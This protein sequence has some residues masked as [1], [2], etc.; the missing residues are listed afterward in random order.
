MRLNDGWM[1]FGRIFYTLDIMVW[2]VR[3]LDILS[4]NKLMGPYVNMIGKMVGT[5]QKSKWR[6]AL[7]FVEIYY[8]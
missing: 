6:R 4:V 1:D 5:Q 7:E 8:G 3:V 2:Y